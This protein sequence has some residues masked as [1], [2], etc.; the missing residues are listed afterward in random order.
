[1]TS[2]LMERKKLYDTWLILAEAIIEIKITN[3][4]TLDFYPIILIIIL[5]TN[6]L[7]NEV[8]RHIGSWI[9]QSMPIGVVIRV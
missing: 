4:K 6:T 3:I 8:G 5:T 7:N 2:V 9:W 1:M